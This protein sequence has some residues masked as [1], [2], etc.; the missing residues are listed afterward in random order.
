MKEKKIGLASVIATSMGMI[1]ATSCLTSLGQGAGYIGL[2]FI[3]S[4]VIACILNMMTMSSLSELNALMPNITGGLAQYSLAA[5]G[6]FPTI[7]VMIGGTM[8]MAI[9][10]SGV[11]ASIF[12]AAVG[13]MVDLPVSDVMYAQIV[14]VILMILNLYGVDLFAKVQDISAYLL[15]AA[16]FILGLIGA[17]KLG[18]GT[19]VTQPASMN[20]G[21]G[22]AIGMSAG[23]FWLFI[24]AENSI[25][26]AKDAKNPR[27]DIPL[28]MMAA[29]GLICVV[30][31][32]LVLGFHN[33]TY[34]TELADSEAPHMLYGYNLLGRPGQYIMVVVASLAL[35]S[36]QN[37]TLHGIAE[38]FQGMAKM[39]M[40]PHAFAKT[41]KHHAP[42]FGIIFLT[43]GIMIFTYLSVGS[44]DTINFFINVCS[45]F[46]MMM[47]V[48]AHIDVFIFRKRLPKAPRTFRS[49]AIVTALGLAGT[50]YMIW[51]IGETM[52][53]RIQILTWDFGILVILTIYA[54]WWI[55]F[56][57]KMPVFKAV[58]IHKVMAMEDD[59]YY[60]LRRVRGI[61]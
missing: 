40:L 42:A 25:P 59:R 24:G 44:A 48:F 4:M 5:M 6:P 15:I 21:M 56:K 14:S 32:V 53:E 49:P 18:T 51:N 2:P 34:W 17:L 12:A 22:A 1:V 9:V 19:P 31:S 38:V 23:A 33:Y 28:G 10:S 43:V 37:T 3:L 55:K 8:V 11:E 7:V 29:L 57:M 47:Y 45:V 60:K 52:Q 13:E 26:L 20:G 36:T 16:L 50:F 46:S 61:W 27:R 30:Q 35:I 54:V 41:N 58:P 39:N